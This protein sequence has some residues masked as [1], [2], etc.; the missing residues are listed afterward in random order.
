VKHAGVYL[1]GSRRGYRGHTP[2]TR[3]VATLDP[4]AEARAIGRGDIVKLESITPSL[5]PG[6]YTLPAGW[7]NHQQEEGSTDGKAHRTH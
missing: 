4:R 5:R 1:V 6:S 7:L 3:F 2:G